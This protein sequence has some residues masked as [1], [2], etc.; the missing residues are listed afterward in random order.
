MANNCCTT[1]ATWNTTDAPHDVTVFNLIMMI[2]LP[3]VSVIGLCGNLL[4]LWV[5]HDK[6]MKRSS[7]TTYLSVR[8]LSDTGFL[9]SMLV[10]WLD[11]VDVRLFHTDVICQITVFLSYVCSFLSVWCVTYAAL[12]NY[13]RIRCPH[14]VSVYCQPKI[15]KLVTI[16]TLLLSL[17][18]YNFP[19]WST[20]VYV[21][22]GRQYCQ[23]KPLFNYFHQIAVYCDTILTLIL[24]FLVTITSMFM[25]IVGQYTG[26]N[27]RLRMSQRNNIA[28]RRTNR[29]N[30]VSQFLFGITLSFLILHTPSHVIRLRVM[31]LSI[32]KGTA[33]TVSFDMSDRYLKK[34]SEIMYYSN[35]SLN[36]LIYLVCGVNFRRSLYAK[37]CG[38]FP[39][40]I[41][42]KY[43]YVDTNKNDTEERTS[44]SYIK[45]SSSN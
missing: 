31:I 23:P 27:R 30:K 9:V 35:F 37:L 32:V 25:V 26:Y 29:Q 12:E 13:I 10:V 3:V 45:N 4:V 38:I 36:C 41:K 17:T 24:P 19:L 40:P 18:L 11:T 39:K 1:D 43:G 20:S 6:P 2:Y 16:A 34:I 21:I 14:K 7:F 15:A 42:T 33:E 28:K 8:S 22:E 5:F 44:Q